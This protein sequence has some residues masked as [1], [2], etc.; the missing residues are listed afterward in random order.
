MRCSDGSGPRQRRYLRMQ[1]SYRMKLSV[2]ALWTLTFPCLF[3]QTPQ[4]SPGAVKAEK[5]DLPKSTTTENIWRKGFDPSTWSNWALVAVGAVG[6][7]F[8]LRT[9]RAIERQTISVQ[10]Q[11]R[12]IKRQTVAITEG[13]RPQIAI[14]PSGNPFQDLFD[15]TPRIALEIH[16]RGVTPARSR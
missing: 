5:A 1:R 15:R 9:L 7:W 10:R 8:A 16:N 2:V 13:Q 11:T 12:S 14:D 3:S 6:T 4:P